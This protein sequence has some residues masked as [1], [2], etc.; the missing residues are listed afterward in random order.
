MSA[1]EL[2]A[3][4]P[5][6]PTQVADLVERTRAAQR[7]VRAEAQ[8]ARRRLRKPRP[9][10]K[11]MH[12]RVCAT[13]GQTGHRGARRGK[14]CSLTYRAAL[15]V[16]AGSHSTAAAARALNVDRTCVLRAVKRQRRLR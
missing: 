3:P 5:F 10:P 6:T 16:I 14:G 1:P 2:L 12:E 9:G 7:R 8:A 13:C 15:L 4:K 11:P